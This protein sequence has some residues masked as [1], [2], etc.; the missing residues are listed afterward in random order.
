MGREHRMEVDISESEF[1]AAINTVVAEIMLE[2]DE[3]LGN[4]DNY[5]QEAKKKLGVIL[6]GNEIKFVCMEWHYILQR[7]SRVSI[8]DKIYL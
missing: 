6:V 5:I 4:M 7:A 8:A 2:K 3:D 1:K